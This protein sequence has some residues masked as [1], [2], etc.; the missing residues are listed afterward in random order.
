MKINNLLLLYCRYTLLQH[1]LTHIIIPL[2]RLDVYQCDYC[3]LNL[4][5]KTELNQHIMFKHSEANRQKTLVKKELIT[6]TTRECD[7]CNKKY[8]YRHWHEHMRTVH[9]NTKLTCDQCQKMFKCKKYLYRHMQ[10]HGGKP[11]KNFGK[12]I[13]K[14]CPKALK[15]QDCLNKHVKNCHGQIVHCEICN[16]V[17]KSEVYLSS[18]MRRVHCDKSKQSKCKI[19][20]KHFKSERQVRIHISNTHDKKLCS[21]CGQTYTTGHYNNYHKK[22][23]KIETQKVNE[24]KSGH[25]DLDVTIDDNHIAVDDSHLTENRNSNNH[26]NFKIEI[27]D[28]NNPVDI[29]DNQINGNSNDHENFKIDIHSHVKIE[30]YDQNIFNSHDN[31]KNIGVDFNELKKEGKCEEISQISLITAGIVSFYHDEMD[32]VA[33]HGNIEN[34]NDTNECLLQRDDVNDVTEDSVN[35]INKADGHFCKLCNKKLES[36]KRIKI[37]MK[38]AHSQNL[39]I[40][41]QYCDTFYFN[42]KYFK[43][44]VKKCKTQ[45]DKLWNTPE[46]EIKVKTEHGPKTKDIYFYQRNQ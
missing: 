8:S 42:L 45:Q 24:V 14:Q 22:S 23:C 11:L 15:S 43:E 2:A 33:I 29:G 37:H 5:K 32:G 12:F 31:M 26:V 4:T 25:D 13:C 21:K 40:K 19:C 34:I 28:H 46:L 44:H 35:N 16:S 10:K 41:C 36:E 7:I 1:H 9:G 38:N 20:G 6:N 18:H 27:Q 39:P 3:Q 30:G 17:L